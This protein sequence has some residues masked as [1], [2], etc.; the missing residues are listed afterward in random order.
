VR[1]PVKPGSAIEDD[2]AARALLRRRA[3]ALRV[4]P[5]EPN[6]EDRIVWVAV[7]NVGDGSFAFPLAVLRGILP[8]GAVTPVPLAGPNIV[9]VTRFQGR[10]VT[11]LSL[12]SLLGGRAWVRDPTNLLV[13]DNDDGLIAVDCMDVPRTVAV[14]ARAAPDRAKT[15]DDA[16]GEAFSPITLAGGEAALLVDVGRL[17]AGA[18]VG[19][20][21]VSGAPPSLRRG[22]RGDG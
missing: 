3:E 20:R 18:H 2:V 16:F 12:A 17:V 21:P 15:S 11:V 19:K 13:L 7:C 1:Q 5:P 9:G 8:L 6:D 10:L 14:E 22:E 4:V